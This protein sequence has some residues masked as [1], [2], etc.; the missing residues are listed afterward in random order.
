M[1]NHLF[2]AIGHFYSPIP[3]PAE[4][5]ERFRA[6]PP[7]EAIRAVPGIEIDGASMLRLWGELTQY[8][9][10]C[11]FPIEPQT[12]HRYYFKND[13]YSFGDAFVLNSMIHH[14]RPRRL[15]EIGSGFSSAVVLDTRD[16]CGSPNELTFI[17]PNPERLLSLMRESDSAQCSIVVDKIQHVDLQVFRSFGTNDV[18]FVD[19]SHVVKTGNDL[20]HVMFEVPPASCAW[21]GHPLS[22]CILALRIS[23][24]MGGKRAPRME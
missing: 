23:T 11:K 21:N 24:R 7:P 4:A 10:N 5:A 14:L 18:L 13:F 2:V 16:Q 8:M 1:E 19:S 9:L 12:T 6:L 20:Q 15:V 3:D 22:R 17:E